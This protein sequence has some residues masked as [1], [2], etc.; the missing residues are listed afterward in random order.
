MKKN[1]YFILIAFLLF[2]SSCEKEGNEPKQNFE[3]KGYAQKGPYRSG[4]NI[5]VMELKDNLNATGL[6][7]YTTVTDNFGSFLIPDVELSSNYAEL[8]ADGFYFNENWG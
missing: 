3:I 5:T 8:M 7:Y 2:I 1:N 6:N 4:T